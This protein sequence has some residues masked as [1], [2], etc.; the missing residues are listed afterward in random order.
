MRERGVR[1]TGCVTDAAPDRSESRSPT[2][3]LYNENPRGEQN[4]A[5]SAKRRSLNAELGGHIATVRNRLSSSVYALATASLPF[6][7]PRAPHQT[8][9]RFAPQRKL[10]QPTRLFDQQSVEETGSRTAKTTE[11]QREGLVRCQFWWQFCPSLV[12]EADDRS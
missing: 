3:E 10:C 8:T 2:R 6:V 12:R 7:V 4:R 5:V 11:R 9:M 1:A